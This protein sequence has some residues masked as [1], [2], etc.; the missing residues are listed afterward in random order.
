MAQCAISSNATS[1]TTHEKNPPP[2]NPTP[3]P[4]AAGRSETVW[5]NTLTVTD[6]AQL[7]ARIATKSQRLDAAEQDRRALEQARVAA[8]LWANDAVQR[9]M[10]QLFE[11]LQWHV[12][13]Y[14]RTTGVELRL[15][16]PRRV[17][18]CDHE[19]QR[20][21]LS[22]S[23]KDDNID[24]YAQWSPG[25]PPGLHLLLSRTRRGRALRMICVPGAWL[26]PST[27]EG[28]VNL[29]SFEGEHTLVSLES[30]AYRAVSLLAME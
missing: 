26:S 23:L 24:L 27:H 2:S 18:A 1:R 6:W 17:L 22:L 20:L 29:R 8:Q 11:L 25:T 30:L 28:G 16:P 10:T 19:A 12:G 14:A 4:R 3:T 7:G 5:R 15:S 13:Q 21:V 9:V